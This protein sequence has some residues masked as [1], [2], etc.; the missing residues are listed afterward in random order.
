MVP[1]W[2]RVLQR[3]FWKIFFYIE[4]KYKSWG[5]V[6][7]LQ[8]DYEISL[9]TWEYDMFNFKDFDLSTELTVFP[10]LSEKKRFRIDYN[11]T[12]KYDLPLDFYVKGTLN[13][14]YDNQ[15][16][17]KGNDL[18]YVFSTGFGWEL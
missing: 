17:I 11:F 5:F 2:L 16:A 18:D 9:H 7:S 10:S 14:N 3:R 15:P 12:L 4:T 6:F 1:H 13:L 8:F